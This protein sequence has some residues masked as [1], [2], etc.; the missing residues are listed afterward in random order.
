MS[1]GDVPVVV[2]EAGIRLEKSFEPDDFP[3]PVIAFVVDSTRG[4]PVSVRVAE[5][6]PDGIPTGDI[7]FH[8]R[9]GSDHWTI[10]DGEIVFEREFAAGEEYTTVYGLRATPTDD[11]GRFLTEPR[12]SVEPTADA[13]SGTAVYGEGTGTG[14]GDRGS[15]TRVFGGSDG[16]TDP[17]ASDIAP[18][19]NCGY[20]LDP[21]PMAAHCPGCGS[22]VCGDCGA[23]LAAL[24]TPTYCPDC[25]ADQ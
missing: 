2:E 10:V 4:H 5:S 11:V 16:P 9:Y 7:G 3:V 23:D 14:S 24:S 1:G 19:S 18:C 25:G 20:D 6:I 17:Y 21:I 15:G 22:R 12:L 13:G 8:P